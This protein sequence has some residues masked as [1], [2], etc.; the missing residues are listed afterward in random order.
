[1]RPFTT[2]AIVI[3]AVICLVHILRIIFGWEV[4]VD[5][6]VIPIWVSGVGALLAGLLAVMVWKESR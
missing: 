5:H 2:I 4:I 6:I 1:M 3:F